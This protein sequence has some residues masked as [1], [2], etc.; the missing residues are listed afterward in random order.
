M[1]TYRLCFFDEDII[2]GR[3]DFQAYDDDRAVEIAE[4]LF[5]AC[6]DRCQSWG[7]W[8]GNVLLMGGPQILGAPMRASDLAER[9]QENIVEC[10]ETILQS[11]WA[12]A[13]STRLLAE[14]D[15]LKASKKGASRYA[16]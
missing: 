12:V 6:S 16:L 14:L 2:R 4:I 15:K 3:F 11:E 1:R 7:I 13:S 9:R 5:D 8:D 10:E